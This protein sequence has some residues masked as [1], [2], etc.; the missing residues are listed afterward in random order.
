MGVKSYRPKKDIISSK[1]GIVAK[2][3]VHALCLTVMGYL[4]YLF[5]HW[6][7]KYRH[8]SEEDCQIKEVKMGKEFK[9]REVESFEPVAPEECGTVTY[10][11]SNPYSRVSEEVS[12]ERKYLMY[13]ADM[14]PLR[15]MNM[16]P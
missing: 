9:N 4:I 8:W 2:L 10:F 7:K 13:E 6:M 14:D 16:G 15:M 11:L 12:I 3:S 1:G 5:Y